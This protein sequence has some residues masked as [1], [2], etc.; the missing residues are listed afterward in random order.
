MTSSVR[1]VSGTLFLEQKTQKS[2]TGVLSPR[3]FAMRK[4]EQ[5]SSRPNQR[6]K[7]R[8]LERGYLELSAVGFTSELHDTLSQFA[9]PDHQPMNPA[10]VTLVEP[11]GGHGD[12]SG[13]EHYNAP[14]A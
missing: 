9:L 7:E 10:V 6:Y 3:V 13:L 8:K 11:A 5:W 14:A 4:I 12:R 2:S 1:Q